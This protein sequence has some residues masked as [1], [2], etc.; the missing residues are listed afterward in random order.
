[1]SL[2]DTHTKA[3]ELASAE[4]AF[5]EAL[6]IFPRS[7]FLRVQYALFL[8]QA[9]RIDAEA[10]Q[11]AIARSVDMRQTNGWFNFLTTGSV[12]A[13]QRALR[14]PTAAP[15]AELIPRDTAQEYLDREKRPGAPQ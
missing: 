14:D 6:E 2:A 4:R 15:P 3:G 1:M 8:H 12:T 7:G 11:M 5:V 10:N 13:S 9:T